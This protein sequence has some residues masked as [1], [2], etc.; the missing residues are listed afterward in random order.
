MDEMSSEIYL[1][2]GNCGFGVDQCVI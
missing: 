1:I 2:D